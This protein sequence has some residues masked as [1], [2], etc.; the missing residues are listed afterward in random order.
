MTQT[1][2]AVI[3]QF[4]ASFLFVWIV[5]IK[6][7]HIFQ[8]NGYRMCHQLKWYIKHPKILLYTIGAL[9]ASIFLALN[10]VSTSASRTSHALTLA[11][12]TLIAYSQ[13]KKAKTPIVYTPRVKRLLTT[14]L[15]VYTAVGGFYVFD[16]IAGRYLY[17]TKNGA[18]YI[19]K[20]FIF[21]EAILDPIIYYT[22]I[23]ILFV[24]A[25]VFV[26]NIINMPIEKSIN[27]H[28]INDAKNILNNAKNLTIIGVTGSYGKTSTKHYIASLLREKYD[29]LMTPQSYNTPLG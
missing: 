9:A 17:A 18:R 14:I 8:L 13:T 20:D 25:L 23:C 16:F 21:G 26:A 10:P 12:I 2:P 6:H 28:Y 1:L 11:I 15:A 19:L 29:V 22:A 7:L 3:L 5:S 27:R 24:P 4:I